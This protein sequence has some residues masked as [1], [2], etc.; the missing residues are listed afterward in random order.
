MSR[1]VEFYIDDHQLPLVEPYRYTACGLDNIYLTNGVEILPTPDSSA[2]T[3]SNLDGLQ[4][5]IGLYIVEKQEPMSG[6]EFRFLRK[7]MKLT[8]VDLAARMRISNQTIANYEKENTTLG[9]AEPLMR[10]IYLL[11]VMPSE[12][13]VRLL[14]KFTEKFGDP[15][16]A[17]LADLPRRKLAENWQERVMEAA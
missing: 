11:H 16:A 7:Q 9:P 10:L 1:R 14:K 6:P 2:V 17:K 15:H 12:S 3:I 13:R 4:R 5:A 8:Q